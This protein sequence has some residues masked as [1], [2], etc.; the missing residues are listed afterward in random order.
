MMNP[1]LADEQA[2][3]IY[4]NIMIDALRKAIDTVEK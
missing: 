2:F 4:F 1:F 3:G